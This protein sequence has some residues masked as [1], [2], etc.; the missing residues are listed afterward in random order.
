MAISAR[1]KQQLSA[2][3]QKNFTHRKCYGFKLAKTCWWV[4]SKVWDCTWY[5]D[6]YKKLPAANTLKSSQEKLQP[7][8][9]VELTKSYICLSH[10]LLHETHTFQ[11]KN[12]TS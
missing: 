7:F 8:R 12:P 6:A 2:G 5:L 9:Q 10:I 3:K 1:L 4:M 11:M